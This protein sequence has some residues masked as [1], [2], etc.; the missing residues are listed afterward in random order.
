[1]SEIDDDFDFLAT[2]DEPIDGE[3]EISTKTKPL[4][5]RLKIDALLEE[6]RLLKLKRALEGDDFFDFDDGFDDLEADFDGLDGDLDAEFLT[7]ESTKQVVAKDIEALLV[8]TGKALPS[9]KSGANEPIDEA[10]DLDDLAEL[11]DADT[12]DELVAPKKSGAVPKKSVNKAA[13]KTDSVGAKAKAKSV[14]KSAKTGAVTDR[15]TGGAKDT[16][17]HLAD[18]EAASKAAA[19][20]KTPKKPRAKKAKAPKAAAADAKTDSAAHTDAA[21]QATSKSA[22]AKKVA[23]KNRTCAADGEK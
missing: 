14:Q 4:E 6:Q 15:A 22:R 5:K 2:E 9:H 23:N 12:A 3:A 11:S 18:K 13:T 17:D 8:K 20:T 21:P 7:K 19:D 10:E 16:V 1:M